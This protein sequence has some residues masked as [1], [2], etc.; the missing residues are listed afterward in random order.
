[1]DIAGLL[2]MFG[3]T[4]DKYPFLVLGILI[5]AGFIYLR[6]SIGNKLGKVKDNVLIIITHLSASASRRGRLDTALIQVMSPMVITEQGQ[7]VL[8][9]S[10]FKNIIATPEHRA[11]FIAYIQAQ[12]PNTKLDVESYSIIS[13]STFLER[14]FMN[15]IK[16][17]LYNNPNMRDVYTTL[18]GLFIRDEYL[19][20]HPEITQ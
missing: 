15:P 4:H 20:D 1:M 18:A 10:G 11:E 5:V 7:T 8:N 9:E 6:F 14:E 19:K 13:F 2:E 16:T 12:N 3:I 17:Y